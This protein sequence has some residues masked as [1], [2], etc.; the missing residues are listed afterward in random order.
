[1]KFSKKIMSFT[2]LFILCTAVFSG[3]SAKSNTVNS[4]ADLDGKH[5]GVQLDTVGDTYASDIH[6]A[7]VE[8]FFDGKEAVKSLQE[9]KIDAVIIDVEPAKVYVEQNEDITI[10]DEAFAEEKYA[11]ALKKGNSELKDQIN[12]ALN[13][14]KADGTMNAIKDNWIGEN[15]ARKPY[16][17]SY[18]DTPTT[19]KLVMATNATFAPYEFIENDTVIGFDVDMMKAVCHKLNMKLVIKNMDF[20]MI[21]DSVVKGDADVGVAGITVTDE[22]LKIV[23]FS[24]PYTTATQVVIVRKN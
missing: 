14:L 11:I 20:D 15:A 1:M 7:S 12:N 4:I 22:R 10:L 18:E 17:F 6:N 16:N 23:D 3:C 9:G 2:T 13:E 21:T 24:D 5:I 19:Q 8:K